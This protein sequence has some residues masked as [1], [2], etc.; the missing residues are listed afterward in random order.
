[1]TGLPGGPGGPMGPRGPGGPGGPGGP[2]RKANKVLSTYNP[3]NQYTSKKC[4][5]F[6]K[7]LIIY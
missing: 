3:L 2:W 7:D 1:M 5:N 6:D 4:F